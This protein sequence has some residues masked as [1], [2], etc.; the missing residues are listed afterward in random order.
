MSQDCQT[1]FG[2]RPDSG[3]VTLVVSSHRGL[4]FVLQ[5]LGAVIRPVILFQK[6]TWKP[7]S[8][9][10]SPP[11]EKVHKNTLQLSGAN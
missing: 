2:Q 7:D 4:L 8:V 3:L 10:V 1:E 11:F 9:E 6:I 5:I